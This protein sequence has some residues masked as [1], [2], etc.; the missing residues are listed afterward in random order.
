MHM[1]TNDVQ[2]LGNVGTQNEQS[3]IVARDE[4]ESLL[5]A[6]RAKELFYVEDG[7]LLNRVL[8]GRRGM[9]GMVA[10]SPDGF[11]YLRVK[12]DNVRYRVHRIIW[13]ITYG[14]WPIGQIDHING[15][16]DDNRI[17]NLREV[18]VQD[19]QRNSHLRIDNTS[20]VTGVVRDHGGWRARI[21]VDGKRINLGFFKTFEEA[22][23]ARK[24]GESH[25][26][27]HP[28]HGATDEARKSG[29]RPIRAPRIL[30]SA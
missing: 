30:R 16:R 23:S 26:G 24:R 1:L 28:N 12:V 10:G 25:F 21:K 13:L 4:N 18:S 5:T 14:R 2:E 22:V 27:F 3:L 8:R 29:L 19:N 7:L 6:E 17:E 20:G 9:P 15:V 11:G